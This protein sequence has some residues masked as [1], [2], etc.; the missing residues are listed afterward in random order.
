VLLLKIVAGKI[1]N[2]S[3]LTRNRN[4]YRYRYNLW[5]R[6]FLCIIKILFAAPFWVVNIST[7]IIFPFYI[8]VMDIDGTGIRGDYTNNT[9][10]PG[11]AAAAASAALQSAMAAREACASQ[12]A[13]DQP[14][15]NH[16]NTDKK[17]V[18]AMQP[19]GT[20][21]SVFLQC[22]NAKRTS[23]TGDVFSC[24]PSESGPVFSA[25]T[26]S[27]PRIGSM[28]NKDCDDL[29]KT[30]HGARIMRKGV[31]TNEVIT[32][33]FDPATMNCLACPNAHRI[34]NKSVPV[35]LCFSDQNFVPTLNSGQGQDCI[36]VV[37]YE[38]ATLA[39][40][41][42]IALEILDKNMIHPGSVLLFGSASHLFRVGASCYA[43]DWVGLISKLEQKFRNVNICPLVP[44]LRESCPGSLAADIEILATWLNRMY[45]NNIKGMADSWNAVVHFAQNAASGQ[46]NFD[47]AN[48]VKIPLPANL[49][50]LH[51]KFSPSPA[52]WYGLYGNQRTSAHPPNSPAKRFLYGSWPGG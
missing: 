16:S 33:S 2:K 36:A 4:M 34:L 38:D 50:T 8:S 3:L 28:F 22:S 5:Y 41:T 51:Q 17:Q 1:L 43:A 20:P 19:P 29:Q 37:R 21:S 27:I 42:A 10:D 45:T 30:F 47:S 44:V 18:D 7:I 12:P 26:T 46:I 39:D 15:D 6:Y 14:A 52:E 9:S 24:F 25:V 23:R 32:C 13:I 48:F 49:S 31:Q 11:L 35:T 40:L